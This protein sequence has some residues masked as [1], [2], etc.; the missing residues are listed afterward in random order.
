M[1][2]FILKCGVV[3]AVY[4]SS[5]VSRLVEVSSSKEVF[6]CYFIGLEHSFSGPAAKINVQHVPILIF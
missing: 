1:Y 6:K 2:I 4:Y 3:Y 5:F